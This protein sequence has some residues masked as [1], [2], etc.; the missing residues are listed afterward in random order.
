MSLLGL[1]I[2]SMDGDLPK[3]TWMEFSFVCLPPPVDSSI[4][5]G[6]VRLGAGTRGKEWVTVISGEGLII[7]WGL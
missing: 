7:A 6:H 2:S 1:L 4:P 5:Q 3:A